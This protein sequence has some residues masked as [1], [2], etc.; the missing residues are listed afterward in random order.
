MISVTDALDPYMRLIDADYNTITLDNTPVTCDDSGNASLCWGESTALSN[1]SVSRS[2]G[3]QLGGFQY[4][5][6]L[7]I[8]NESLG[9][10]PDEDGYLN[11]LMTS[12]QQS[13][14]GDY[15]VAFHL[16]IGDV[17]GRGS[18]VKPGTTPTNTP[19]PPPPSTGGTASAGVVADC[20]GGN[21][22]E[23]G[24]EVIVNM[25]SGFTYT[26]TAIGI[27]GFDPVLAVRAPN[28]D[29]L[30]N[31][32]NSAAAG[33]S[34]NLPTTGAVNSS[35]LSAQQPFSHNISGLANISLIVGGFG[36]T[37]GEF[38]LVVEG[39]AVTSADGSGDRAGD[40][41]SVHV[42]PNM[43]ASGVP[44]SA[45]MISV[46]N[47]TDPY[48]RLI[49]PEYNTGVLD[50]APVICDDAG[51]AAL[52]WGESTALTNS[53]VSRVGG[54]QLGGFQYDAMLTIPYESLG[55]E[56]DEDGYLNLLMTTYQ[57]QTFGDYLVAF[58]LG[59]SA[60]SG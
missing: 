59:T 47:A 41:F 14:F 34:A 17:N 8:P 38:V 25:R 36:N 50:N 39:L 21:V 7:T 4:D 49:D 28:G 1:S 12:Y 45:Y 33:Y 6:M 52:C 20:G 37:P 27:D 58:H 53:F 46:T 24:V 19:A 55:L 60:V 32:D 42:T 31:D 43:M 57:Q 11:F 15:E 48:M 26:A 23:N 51:D 9:L 56:P 3:R 5:A 30:C 54:R 16:G 22:I 29:I 2:G 44:V 10:E 13:Y 40:P 18:I 35:T